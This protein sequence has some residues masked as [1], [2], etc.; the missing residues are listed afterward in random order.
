VLDNLVRIPG[1]GH[2]V[3]L[4]PLIG[5][6]PV[7]GD[8]VGAVMSAWIIV[9]AARFKL[10]AIVLLRMIMYAVVDFTLGLVPILGD[11]IDLGFKANDRNLELFHRHA[12]DPG[13]STSSSWALV[14]GVILA[15]AG[16]IWLAIVL[17][18][19][20]LGVVVG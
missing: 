4:D 16:M 10:P 18:S 15:F 19:R 1:T 3:G 12:V 17:L 9:E 2:R 11:V 5:L 20:L 14:G 8:L 13:A 7:W 6:V